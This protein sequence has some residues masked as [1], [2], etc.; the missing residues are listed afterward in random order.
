[1]EENIYSTAKSKEFK[2]HRKSREIRKDIRE[3]RVLHYDTDESHDNKKLL[4][5]RNRPNEPLHDMYRKGFSHLHVPDFHRQPVEE[6]TPRRQIRNQTMDDI[7]SGIIHLLGGDVHVTRPENDPPSVIFPSSS[8]P[9]R[10]NDRGPAQFDGYSRRKTTPTTPS[11]FTPESPSVIES[12]VEESSTN[13]WVFPDDTDVSLI[14][15][16]INKTQ[17]S[18]EQPASSSTNL[19]S[20]LG[21]NNN[22]MDS[23][24]IS[25]GH[26]EIVEIIPSAESGTHFTIASSST[27]QKAEGP[28]TLLVTQIMPT[29]VLTE[30]DKHGHTFIE[31][32]VNKKPINDTHSSRTFQ[33]STH[34][35]HFET[36]TRPYINYTDLPILLPSRTTVTSEVK[37]TER[38]TLPSGP[39]TDWLPAGRPP[40]RTG[41]FSATYTPD[42]DEPL[43]ITREPDNFEITITRQ[44]Y[45]NESKS[46]A[47]S[48]PTYTSLLT[49]ADV[50]SSTDISVSIVATQVDI[51][52]GRPSVSS[53][54]PPPP[55]SQAPTGRPHVFP[56]DIDE[57]R[58][59]KRPH[60]YPR[61]RPPDIPATFKG[62][63][64][65]LPNS[66]PS[67]LRK[68][69]PFRIQ[70][71]PQ[72]PEIRYSLCVFIYF[73]MLNQLY[74]LKL[75]IFKFSSFQS[76]PD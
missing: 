58:P 6:R 41:D 74:Y 39:V 33:A 12:K 71:Q 73:L 57:V 59:S 68:P 28:S 55:P 70:P 22:F 75:L 15:G 43:I 26:L 46:E 16:L 24:N 23:G 3:G 1:M 72:E 11:S 61:P 53:V 42:P 13:R 31:T 54:L 49:P 17:T 9:T 48:V 45:T 44:M 56:V 30:L 38:E 66:R 29:G 47:E 76:F 64:R 69:P 27:S 25:S 14:L 67:I 32:V 65:P 10:I 7:I 20:Y 18:T 51:I 60:V 8:R 40:V 19:T 34:I 36:T 37:A 50:T 63:L 52:Y 62:G 2:F 21:V 5:L 4:L 35:R